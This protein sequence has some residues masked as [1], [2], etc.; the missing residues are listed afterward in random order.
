MEPLYDRLVAVMAPL[1]P[2]NV[3]FQA[4]VTACP[5]GSVNRRVQPSTGAVEVFVIFTLTVKPVDHGFD[6]KATRQALVG[7]GL[8]GDGVVGDGLVGDGLVGDGL[9]TVPVVVTLVVADAGPLVPVE[10]TALT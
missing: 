7:D 8:V 6:S 1:V 9:V 4:P 5:E 3:A 10:S 2:P